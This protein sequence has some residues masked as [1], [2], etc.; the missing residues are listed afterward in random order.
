MTATSRAESPALLPRERLLMAVAHQPDI[1]LAA[2]K[3]FGLG[4]EIQCFSFPATL[5][6]DYRQPLEAMQKQVETIVGPIGCHGAFIDTC[7]FSP[8]PAIRIV[9]QQRYVESMDIAAALGAQYIVFHSQYNPAIKVRQYPQVYHQENLIVWPA[10]LEEARERG[11]RVY[12]ENMFDQ[13]PEPMARLAEA[14][15]TPDFRICF[16]IAHSELFSPC[17]LEDWIAAL[18][19]FIAHVHMNDSYGEFD[20]HLP[21]GMGTLDLPRALRL[22]DRIA[23]DATYTLETGQ[24]IPGSLAYLGISPVQ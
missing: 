10:L 12:I 2:A 23:P 18:G 13:T 20:D 9:A 4:A 24:D 6:T 14:L 7:P 21:L 3:Q 19:P 15:D 11:L 1:E 22:L 5:A 8:D 16:D 17:P